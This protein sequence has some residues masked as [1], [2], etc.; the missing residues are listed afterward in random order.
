MTGL[1]KAKNLR[2]VVRKLAAKKGG[3]GADTSAANGKPHPAQGV[4]EFPKRLA[5]DDVVSERIIFEVGNTRFA[6]KCTAEIEQL[7]PAGPVAVERKL[8]SD[9]SRQ[10][11]RSL[12]C[13]QRM[14]LAV[15]ENRSGPWLTVIVPTALLWKRGYSVNRSIRPP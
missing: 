8:K 1:R 3:P 12:F 6:F 9:R 7:P 13:Q 10:I 5:A 4:I 14:T 11:K 2:P 15:R